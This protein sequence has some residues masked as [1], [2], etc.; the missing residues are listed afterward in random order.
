MTIAGLRRLRTGH[1]YRRP[2]VPLREV[3]WAPET[4]AAPGLW[5]EWLCD[6]P[7]EQPDSMDWPMARSRRSARTAGIENGS[8]A[9]GGGPVFSGPPPVGIR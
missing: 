2:Y 5:V 8:E 6:R 4:W 9:G 3:E 7:R 1:R